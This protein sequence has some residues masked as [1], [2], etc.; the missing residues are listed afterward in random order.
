MANNRTGKNSPFSRW[1]ARLDWVKQEYPYGPIQHFRDDLG[2]LHRTNGP[3]YISPTS[4]I[5]Y[6]EGRKHGLSVD[7]WG[8]MSYWFEGISVPRC[9]V[10]SPEE[11]T[12]K[13]VFSYT[14]AEVRYVG[15]K[16]LDYSVIQAS[17]HYALIDHDDETNAELFHI[18]G[19]FTEPMAMVKVINGSPEPDGTYKKYFLQVPPDEKTCKSAIAWTFRKTETT[20]NPKVET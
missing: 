19:I 17:E 12:L 15:V 3:A 2:R 11:L 9:F 6:E 7:V 8:S 10:M 5:W 4:C 18:E 16:I 1:K 14:N 20:Y 13:D